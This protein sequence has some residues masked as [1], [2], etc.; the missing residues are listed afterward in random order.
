MTGPLAGLYYPFSRSIDVRSLKQ[1]LLF[2]DS[3]AFVDPVTDEEW[4][5]K[6]YADLVPSYDSRF[7]S[8]GDVHSVLPYLVKEKAVT[9]IDPAIVQGEDLK[10]AVASACADLLDP[11]WTNAASKPRKYG[12]AYQADS[13]SRPI[14]EIFKPKLPDDF[15]DILNNEQ[16]NGHLIREGSDISSWTLSYEAGSAIAMNMH[17]AAAKITGFSPVTDSALHHQ[18][19]IRKSLRISNDKSE[20]IIRD[21]MDI[22]NLVNS[23]IYSFI[24]NLL[25]KDALDNASFDDILRFRESTK[26][27][28]SAAMNDISSQM[29]GVIQTGSGKDLYRALNDLRQNMSKELRAYEAE[30]CNVRDK[31]WPDIWGSF[32]SAVVPGSFAA[33]AISFVAGPGQMLAASLLASSPALV[34]TFLRHRADYRSVKR[35]FAPTVAYLSTLKQIGGHGTAA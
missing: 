21:D 33:I 31:L 26:N 34:Q 19:L 35:K 18:L 15:I 12:I 13:N 1:L 32:R 29:S 20:D 3:I 23:A 8:Y 6:L 9:R 14:W 17:L 10:L 4:R 16:I 22:Q 11:V 2:L 24:E 28:R 27:I 25:P 5:A 30:I 7:S